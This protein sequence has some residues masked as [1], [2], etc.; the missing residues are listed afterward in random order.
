MPQRGFREQELWVKSLGW[1]SQ[2]IF[3]SSYDHSF[4]KGALTTDSLPLKDMF[5]IRHSYAKICCGHLVPYM[6]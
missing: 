3:R 4:W 2:N 1:Y 5:T 6:S